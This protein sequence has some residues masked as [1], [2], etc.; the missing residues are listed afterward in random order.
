[1]CNIWVYYSTRNQ[2]YSSIEKAP[3]RSVALVL[4]TSNKLVSGKPNPFFTNRIETAKALIEH[5]KTNHII[6]SG[7][8]SSKYYNE[9]LAMKKALELKGVDKST[10]TPDY[11]GLRT[12]DSI[13][14]CKQIFGQDSIIII[15]QSFHAY[16]ALFI[17][18][19]YNLKAIAV[20]ADEPGR[21]QSAKVLL[22]ECLARPL[23]VLDL[24]ILGTEPKYL[25]KKEKLNGA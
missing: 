19:Y 10:I 13:V 11:A 12:F 7:D 21:W 16:R 22:R 18:N 25:G 8:N 3:Y 15:T 17:S 4:G 23:A 6:V 2:I 24:Y 9:P 20:V 14:R 5:N 1:M